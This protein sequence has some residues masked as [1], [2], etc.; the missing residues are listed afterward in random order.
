ML[1]EICTLPHYRFLDETR[2]EGKFGNEYAFTNDPDQME[3]MHCLP[4]CQLRGDRHWDDLGKQSG[5]IQNVFT[6]GDMRFAVQCQLPGS[7]TKSIFDSYVS[8][9]AN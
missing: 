1:I 9:N 6:H 8:I 4:Y 2:I 7:L 5:P 3:T